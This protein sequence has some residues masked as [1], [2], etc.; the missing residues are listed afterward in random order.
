VE[1]REGPTTWIAALKACVVL[2]AGGYLLSTLP[3]IRGEARYIPW[4]DA[5]VS[6]LALAAAVALVAAR[7]VLAPAER[8]MWAALATAI[9]LWTAGN[10]VWFIQIGPNGTAPV[11]SIS[12]IGFIGFYPGAYLALGLLLRA[13]GTRIHASMW[14]D[15]VVAGLTVAA[16]AA[17]ALF[18]PIA[19]ATGGSLATVATT[20]TYP[21]GDFLV[22]AMIAGIAVINGRAPTRAQVLLAAGLLVFTIGDVRF[23]FLTAR[24]DYETGTPVSAS[25]VVGCA[26]M[27]FAP[28]TRIT[29]FE[30]HWAG[31]RAIVLPF[32]CTI[33]ALAILVASR[34]TAV[35][36]LAFGLAVAA[37]V[38]AVGRTMLTFREVQELGARRAEARTD[39]LTG[40]PNRRA[41]TWHLE[42]VVAGEAPA[43]LLLLDLDHFKEL[44]DTLGHAA[45]DELLRHIGPRLRTALGPADVLARLG[46]DEFGIIVR[47]DE[48][49]RPIV[50][51]QRILDALETP[52]QL[53][54]IGLQVGGSIGIAHHPEHAD[55]AS[56]LLQHAD[57]AMYVAK[58]RRTGVEVYEPGHDRHTRDQ[59]ALAGQLRA[60]IAGGELVVHHQPKVDLATGAI[61]STEALVR[62][63]HPTEGLLAPGAFL[64]IA[65]QTNAMRP[66]ALFVLEAA[67]GDAARWRA[68]GLEI[69]VAV[70][71][72]AANLLDAELPGIVAAALDRHG[73]PATALR[74]E[75][76]ET[77][78]LADPDRC[79]AVLNALRRLGVGV[80]LDDFGTGHAS[81]ARLA[82]LPVDELKID[83]SFVTDVAADPAHRA[84]ARTIVDLG[85]SLG[86]R[87]VAEGIE[88]DACLAAVRALGCDAAQGYALG[89]PVAADALTERLARERRPAYEPG[90]AGSAPSVT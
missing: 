36:A 78:V 64:P 50:V 17:A 28:W 24:G 31:V 81:L 72:A 2:L 58:E 16:L 46:G 40:L 90:R 83:R 25:W 18:A 12:D 71:L 38:L 85:R 29:R 20:L 60:A 56:G 32:A 54:G 70:N 4:L 30:G 10:A 7:A 53:R 66:L 19:D 37:I 80:S 84:I 35:P 39:E 75:V 45:G 62:W 57:V 86:L 43:S 87:V 61:T 22:L 69:E 33:V 77:T 88:D 73:L 11:P 41:M 34:F 52:F 48:D 79:I 44:N 3:L 27:S 76:T 9:G 26:I 68:G 63:E 42:Q 55:D 13:R 67:L 6:L 74:F 51:A 21:V 1:E 23:M 65:E 14:L 59:L 47:R 82:T 49:D 89:R 5:Y 8:W 15:G